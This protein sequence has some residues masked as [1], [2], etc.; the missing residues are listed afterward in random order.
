MIY[1]FKL[2][3]LCGTLCCNKMF[4]PFSVTLSYTL[5]FEPTRNMIYFPLSYLCHADARQ[6]IPLSRNHHY[7]H[8][9]AIRSQEKPPQNPEY[10]L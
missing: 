5:N 2:M 1:L 7:C 3:Q 10:S 4:V 6:V 9:S 8:T